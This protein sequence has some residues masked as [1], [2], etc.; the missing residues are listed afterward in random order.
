MVAAGENIKTVQGILRHANS[1][2]TLDIYAHSMEADKLEAQGRYLRDW[3]TLSCSE[4][5]N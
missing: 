4:S 1:K 2:T 3:N 5:A